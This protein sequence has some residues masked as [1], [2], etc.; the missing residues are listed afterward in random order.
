MGLSW[1][2]FWGKTQIKKLAL[3]YLRYCINVFLGSV[4]LYVK[5][6][7]VCERNWQRQ[8]E[9]VTYK[10][11]YASVCYFSMQARSFSFY[12][13]NNTYTRKQTVYLTYSML[14]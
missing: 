14:K 10:L 12:I 4:C 5:M 13:F 9:D 2:F 3:D 11:N 6:W 1:K 8:G 7:G